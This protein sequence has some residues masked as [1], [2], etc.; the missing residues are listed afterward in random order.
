MSKN[1]CNGPDR[2][3]LHSLVVVKAP[4][5]QMFVKVLRAAEPPLPY[6]LHPLADRYPVIKRVSG[7]QFVGS[8]IAPH[9]SR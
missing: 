6:E 7:W 4:D 8:V 1:A 5:G 2:P 9:A 3:P